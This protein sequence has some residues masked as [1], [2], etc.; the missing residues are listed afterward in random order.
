MMIWCLLGVLC[1]AIE[2]WYCLDIHA[3]EFSVGFRLLLFEH[4]RVV[5]PLTIIWSDLAF[6]SSFVAGDIGR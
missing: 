2:C 1:N 6:G 5:T 3:S 4:L